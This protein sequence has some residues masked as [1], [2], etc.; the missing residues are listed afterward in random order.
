MKKHYFALLL[1]PLFLLILPDCFGGLGLRNE[2][3]RL[4]QDRGWVEARLDAVISLYGITPEGTEALGRLDLRRMRDQPGFF[5][6][7][8]YKGWAGVGEAKP[9]GVM[10][11]LSHSYWGLFPITG[12]PHLGWDRTGGEDVSPAMERYHRDVLEFMQQ[13][14]DRYEPLRDRL[15]NLPQLSSSNL[16][17]LFHTIEADAIYTTAG[18]LELLPPILRKYWDR[19]LQPGPFHSWRSAFQWYGGLSD[20]D[21]RT[22]NRF[23]GF[24]HFDL[25]LYDSLGATDHALPAPGT[26][27]PETKEIVVREERQRLRDFV[28]VFD[29]L[30]GSPE[31]RENFRFWRGYLRDKVDLH[32]RHTGLVTS[33]DLPRAEEIA[34]ALD[35]LVEAGSSSAGER[36]AMVIREL[37]VRPFLANFL[38]ALDDRTLLEMFASEAEL[39]EGATIRGTAAF[40][41]SLERFIPQV[42][43]VLEAG[44]GDFSEGAQ[45]LTSYLS[46]VDLSAPEEKDDLELFFRL[47]QGSDNTT[48]R[49][50]AAAM[51]DSLLR[52]LLK[53]IPTRL[54]FLLAP[55]RF[56]EVVDITPDSTVEE[57]AQGINDMIAYPSGNF[58]IEEPFLD[59]MYRVV[60]ARS[61]ASPGETLGVIAGAPFP[62]ER[63]MLLHPTEAVDIMAIDLGITAGMVKSGDSVTFPP[64]RHIYRLIYADPEFAAR[65]VGQLDRDEED[66]LALEALAQFAYDAD[67]LEAVPGLPISLERDGRFLKRLLEDRG[68]DWLRDRIQDVVGLY[69]QRVS[70]R[71]APGDFLEAYQKTITAAVSSLDDGAAKRGLEEI[72]G[73]VFG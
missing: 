17:P 49:G 21:K 1:M 54:R 34:L 53:P 63:F 33:L 38:P 68:P 12:L 43:R 70:A 16:A 28:E 73:E 64:A 61:R 58:R 10:H 50:V 39:P 56:L 60:A 14:P 22:A 72:I 30:L 41:E 15:R 13:P 57:L 7:Y 36:A 27:G 37:Q 40:V 3:E 19:F 67:R 24:E 66:G 71:E 31:H 52:K 55:A 11:E 6:S 2:Q 8:G 5:G 62:L 20:G 32:K 47:L 23:L 42:N 44:R 48:A 51:D 4:A 26:L 65:V 29:L 46:G 18:D 9:I 45:E 69:G 59:E 35:F 25:S